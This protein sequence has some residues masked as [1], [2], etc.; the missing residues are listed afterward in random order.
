MI[1]FDCEGCRQTLN[2]P[3]RLAGR[4]MKCPGCGHPVEVPALDDAVKNAADDGVLAMTPEKAVDKSSLE[5]DVGPPSYT[6]RRTKKSSQGAIVA[7]LVLLGLAAVGG[8]VFY[9][10]RSDGPQLT[11]PLVNSDIVQELQPIS[12]TI[13][14]G[15]PAGWNGRVRYELVTAP[16]G[17]TL[18]PDAG[19]FSWTPTEEQ[20]PGDYDFTI[21]ALSEDASAKSAEVSFSFEVMELNQLPKIAPIEMV[22]AE[23]ERPLEFRIEAHDPD[24]PAA[25]L[26]L[27]IADGA[28]PE[29]KFDATTGEFRWTPKPEHEGR[30]FTVIFEA[31]EGEGGLKATEVAHIHVRA[32]LRPSERIFDQWR[33]ASGD[34]Q[35]REYGSPLP[36]QGSA[37]V[38]TLNDEPVTVFEFGDDVSRMA[39]AVL[40]KKAIQPAGE[41]ATEPDLRF[42]QRERL[43]VVYAGDDEEVHKQL[44]EQLQAPF[45][46][47]IFPAKEP[48]PEP[49][50]NA[51]PSTDDTQPAN[52]TAQ[53][54]LDDRVYQ[55]FEDKLLLVSKRYPELREAYADYFEKSQ[56]AAIQAAFGDQHAEM[57]AWLD[58]QA[59]MKQLLY[60][61]IN[62]ETDNVERALRLF[63][64]LKQQFPKQIVPYANLAVAIAV[65]WDGENSRGIY[66]YGRHQRRVHAEMPDDL[67]GAVEN[68]RYFVDAKKIMQG[69]AQYL[70]WEFLMHL[71]NHRTPLAERQWAMSNYL[72]QRVGMGKCY[73]DVPYDDEML[74]TDDRICKMDGKEYTLANLKEWGGVCAQQ[75]DFAARVGKSL[76]VP[77]AYVRGE[78]N[79]GGFHAWVMWIE[80]K[81]VTPESIDFELLSHGRYRMDQYYV[82]ELYDPQTNQKITDRE[83]ELRLHVIGS[84]PLA[85]RQAALVM[86]AY[87]MIRDRAEMDTTQQLV[88]LRKVAD[89]CPGLPET[90]D[91]LASMS[92]EGMISKKHSRQMDRSL[93]LFFTTYAGYPDFTWTIFDDLIAHH[94]QAKDRLASYTRLVGMYEAAGRPDLAC[95]ARLKMSDDLVKAEKPQAAIEGLAFTISKFADEGRYVP[96][97][98]DRLEEI[99][100]TVPGTDPRLVRFYQQFL[101]TIPTHR[102]DS[103]SD[104][105]LAMLRRGIAFFEAHQQ[106]ELAKQFQSRLSKLESGQ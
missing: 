88:F 96:R 53:T 72:A 64:E 86:R 75:A 40:I 34:V 103:P 33:A 104:Y 57:T 11:L 22:T 84:N 99:C 81:R 13:A 59:N 29:A 95:E 55:L 62:P 2:A 4:R 28:P 21:R 26:V 1:T 89:L 78:G 46:T 38:V 71:V 37:Q 20:G 39:A 47:G 16:P 25:N 9:K 67:V 106:P 6:A 60:T 105:C 51:K 43:V 50:P 10:M 17:A 100:A 14:A 63:G 56:A 90:W 15:L 97:M 85:H 3:E 87:P 102:G 42:F 12:F 74:K 41:G 94:P 93:E 69:R 19:T 83:L 5:F 92:R 66:D 61:A 76:G 36:I 24:I 80:L 44:T 98:L 31:S 101:P 32:P 27:R 35:F 73:S 8:F 23:S 70:P 48:E 79:S 68:F 49:E 18:D 52:D 58:E 65:T 45:A 77:A 30:E 54:E 7:V 82:G 91:A